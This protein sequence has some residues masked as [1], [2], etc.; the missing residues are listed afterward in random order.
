MTLG[1]N[2]STFYHYSARKPLLKTV[3][4]QPHSQWSHCKSTDP[5]SDSFSWWS[6]NMIIFSVAFTL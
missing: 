3:W 5:K 6:W 2:L 1:E 4:H